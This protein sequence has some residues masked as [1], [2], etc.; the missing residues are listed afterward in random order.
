MCS[1]PSSPS[2]VAIDVLISPCC[3]T[4]NIK[5]R[6]VDLSKIDFCFGGK[7]LEMLAHKYAK[8][9]PIIASR[10]PGTN[11]I[12]IARKASYVMDL[13]DYGYQFERYVTTGSMMGDISPR[14][15]EHLHTMRIGDMNILFRA[16]VDAVDENGSAIEIKQSPTKN[17]RTSI[18][19]R[20]IGS[21]SS[22]LLHGEKEKDVLRKVQMISLSRLS[23]STYWSSNPLTAEG[24]VGYLEQNILEG[25]DDIQ[26]LI[27]DNG[28]YEIRFVDKKIE[29]ARTRN[30]KRRV[31]PRGFVVESL[32][33]RK[34]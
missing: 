33:K 9:G 19:F 14:Q 29:L 21:G 27:Q 8:D 18:M 13:N 1:F 6:G 5:Q 15:V 34:E 3:V 30:P 24:V 11:C 20:L 2:S 22:K 26:R 7:T 25:M 16:E 28:V 32:L 4:T 17:W 12:L 10:V 23:A 31:L